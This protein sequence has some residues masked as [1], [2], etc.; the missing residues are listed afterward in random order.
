MPQLVSFPR[1]DDPLS[2]AARKPVTSPCNHARVSSFHTYTP[3]SLPYHQHL[4]YAH[5]RRA[6]RLCNPDRFQHATHPELTFATN[7]II[8]GIPVTNASLSIQPPPRRTAR[9]RMK[10]T[11]RMMTSPLATRRLPPR[12]QKKRP[13][14]PAPP[15]RPLQSQSPRPQ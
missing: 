3:R 14:P 6:G 10:L 13:L 7:I 2:L 11:T 8:A 9:P 5:H 4:V 12:P 15:P 1:F